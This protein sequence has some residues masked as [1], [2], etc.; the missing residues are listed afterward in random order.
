MA[1][2]QARG[3]SSATGLAYSPS[4]LAHDTGR[5]HPERPERLQAM[6]DGLHASGVWG[7]LSVW[8]PSPVDEPTLELIH[9]R[10]QIESVRRL[11]ERG[12]GH[13]DA[14]T[15]ASPASWEAALRAAGGLV[16]AA[17]AVTTG[18]FQNA[19]CL[20]RPPG[21]H[22]TPH[23]SMGFCLFNN[24][25]IGAEWLIANGR[26]Q[27][28]AI[29]DYDVHH[30]N[31][32]QDA[33]YERG[34]VLYVSTHQYPLYPGTGH[35]T[36]TGAGAG[37][38]YTVNLSL[39]PGS[40]DEVYAAALDR[41]IQPVVRRYA[42]EFVLVSLGFDGFWA[43]PLAMLQLSIGGAY[44]SLLRSA[45]DLAAE[46]CA[47]RLVVGLEGGYDLRALAAGAEAVCRLLLDED[48]PPDPL[49]PAPHQLPVSAAEPVLTSL[50]QRHGLTTAP[51]EP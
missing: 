45:R 51:P 7:R 21:H 33:F 8:E 39:P 18:R 6:V 26:A 17:D 20:V 1:D 23:R 24:V 47:G 5:G 35:W 38:G 3:A 11:I 14:D 10:R 27:R 46:L 32:T 49:G 34:D 43:D 50:E 31:G 4:F 15:V 36:E 29:L 2:T 28:I 16:E 22:A 44:T 19:L 25:A 12:G 9:D 37:V 42:P 13:I 30:G 41:V 48:P 40:G